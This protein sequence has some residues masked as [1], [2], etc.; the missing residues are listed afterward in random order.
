MYIHKKVSRFRG[1]FMVL[2]MIKVS[3]NIDRIT[4]KTF[5]RQ[6]LKI[7]TFRVKFSDSIFF[8]LGYSPIVKSI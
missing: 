2:F 8:L 3:Y 7:F 6:S 5:P 4:K 1:K